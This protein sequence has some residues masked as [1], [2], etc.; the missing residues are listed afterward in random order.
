MAFFGH[1]AIQGG[2]T[3]CWHVKGTKKSASPEPV[4]MPVPL[5]SI[6]FR[7][8]PRY[9]VCLVAQAVS[10]SLQPSHLKGSMRRTLDVMVG[11]RCRPGDSL[12]IE[13][14]SVPFLDKSDDNRTCVRVQEILILWRLGKAYCSKY[15]IPWSCLSTFVPSKIRVLRL[16]M[17][18]TPKPLWVGIAWPSSLMCTYGLDGKADHYEG[19]QACP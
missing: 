10:H 17:V 3:H 19:R 11:S 16:D 5:T 13:P 12:S 7:A 2:S 6:R 9:P 18:G 1:T 8:I 15:D 14:S 4:A